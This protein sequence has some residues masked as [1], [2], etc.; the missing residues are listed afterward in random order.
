MRPDGEELE[1]RLLLGGGDSAS[2]MPCLLHDTAWESNIVD[3]GYPFALSSLLLF[4]T[5]A[6]RLSSGHTHT[7][8]KLSASKV[9]LKTSLK[10]SPL[11]LP[12]ADGFSEPENERL[13]F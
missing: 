12:T 8:T 7:H 4:P 9:Y 3:D 10:G 2:N 6:L 5:P 11:N 13:L 1:L